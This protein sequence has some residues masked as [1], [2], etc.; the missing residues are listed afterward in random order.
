MHDI[1]PNIDARYM[2]KHDP[3]SLAVLEYD[4][5]HASDEYAW[6]DSLIEDEWNRDIQ[7][8]AVTP[9]SHAIISAL[10]MAYPDKF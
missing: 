5:E 1:V 7:A 4:D 9:T 3:I 6:L 10:K 2:H 8:L